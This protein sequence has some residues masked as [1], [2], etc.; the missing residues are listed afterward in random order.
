MGRL[1]H[2]WRVFSL[3]AACIL[4]LSVAASATTY[5]IDYAAGSDSANGTST[6]APWKHMPGM[7][8]C[9]ANCAKTAPK[10]GDKIILKGGV[11]WPNAVFPI[12]W[13]WS[14]SSGSPIYIGVDQTWYTGG[15][16]TRPIFT[17][18]GSP[19]SGTLNLFVHESSGSYVTW[20][21][22]E[23][24][25]LNWT[26]NGS[27]GAIG[28][29]NFGS[30]T[31]ITMSN[32]Y[33]HGWTHSGGL[34]QD[35]CLLI[36]GNT[37]SP[38]SI[39]TLLTHSVIDGSDTTNGGD[40]CSAT[41]ALASATYNVVRNI[42]DVFIMVGSNNE[43]AYNLIDNVT[44]SY[45]GNHE[46][47]IYPISDDGPWYIHDNVIHDG[48]G[49]TIWIGPGDNNHNPTY[50]VWNN[51]LYNQTG[52]NGMAMD[53]RYGTF[54]AY[55]YNNTVTQ[56]SSGNCFLQ[57]AST[58]VV[59]VTLENN[60]CITTTSLDSISS[61]WVVTRTTNLL[62]TPTAATAQGYTSSETYAY[63]PISGGSTIGSGTDATSVWPS[64]YST[65]D[66][67]YACTQSAANQ[68]VCPART[69]V[70]R[71]TRWDVGAYLH[72]ASGA[73]PAAPKHLAAGVH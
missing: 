62:Q 66:I 31:Y 8:G 35:N 1:G 42:P 20:D 49:Q 15:S 60:H 41:Y 17:A 57:T 21:N 72:P 40:S 7:Q 18:G 14:G 44:T 9:T 61:P 25:G 30:S 39:G 13:T 68:V 51:L 11:T 38:Y 43:V 53:G 59:T 5:Y 36:V 67:S 26:S 52:T 63:S 3:V 48:I 2:G 4:A 27:Y 16:W 69:T 56:T 47:A 45:A 46:D 70:P 6:T 71:S 19:I 54:T 34:S 10:A 73:A 22:I 33:F 65:S 28:H 29:I 64:G 55:F 50:Y 23:M 12:I 32:L 24:T 58:Y 37:N